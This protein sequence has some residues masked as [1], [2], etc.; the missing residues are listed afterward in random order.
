MTQSL[1][2]RL[3]FAFA[4]IISSANILTKYVGGPTLWLYSLAV[5]V[6]L[7]LLERW[8]LP[9]LQ[10]FPERVSTGL[11]VSV[12][13]GVTVILALL[14]PLANSGRLG[15]GSDRDEALDQATTSL[16]RGEYPYYQRTYLDNPITP[17]PGS[18]LLA[19]PFVALGSS[20]WQIPVWLIAFAVVLRRWFFD[21]RYVLLLLLSL[22]VLAPKVDHEIVTGGDFVTN[23]MFVLVGFVLLIESAARG[24]PLYIGLAA[25]LV[26]VT[27][28][29]RL[30]WL[31]L[32]P[33][34]LAA[35]AA[36]SSWRTALWAVGLALM[37]FAAVTL[38]WYLY[39]PAGFSPLHTANK[40]RGLNGLM[41]YTAEVTLVLT[42]ITSLFLATRQR[43]TLDFFRNAAIVQAIPVLAGI[44]V[45][46]P[47]LG[48]PYLTYGT[49]YGS[50]YIFFA[51]VAYWL[52]VAR[53]R[54]EAA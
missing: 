23:A 16:L 18:L 11:V 45:P 43:D 51:A 49:F 42:G 22:F 31:S 41:P 10:R 8:G 9:W 26:G 20:I 34:L 2:I 25:L 5:I 37:A 40:L 36:R 50:T 7:W 17:M 30:N 4:I 33:L 39:D 1:L 54:G 21:N 32:M 47:T 13:V 3:L 53:Q 15:P 48:T 27:L 44:I 19:A 6:G 29:S 14:Y 24:R 52:W 38:P 46:T 12:I 35:V 28:S